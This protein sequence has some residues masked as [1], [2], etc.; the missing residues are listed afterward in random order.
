MD[1]G[2][3]PTPPLT[4]GLSAHIRERRNKGQGEAEAVVGC[5]LRPRTTH[6]HMHV[7]AL[8]H[9]LLRAAG[10]LHYPTFCPLVHSINEVIRQMN[11]GSSLRNF[12]NR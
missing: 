5:D 2:N 9:Q 11:P 12:S 3:H 4:P 7:V 1:E 10:A 8:S 6:A